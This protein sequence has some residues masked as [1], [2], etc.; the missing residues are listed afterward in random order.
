[1]RI[2]AVS[3]LMV[4]PIVFLYILQDFDNTVADITV[5]GAELDAWAVLVMRRLCG[6]I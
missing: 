4:V 2:S 5:E 3:L 1:M 6:P